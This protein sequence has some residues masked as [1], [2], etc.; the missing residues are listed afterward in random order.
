MD[1]ALIFNPLSR[2]VIQTINAYFRG[3][4]M[5]AGNVRYETME[6]LHRRNYLKTFNKFH[7]CCVKPFDKEYFI[8]ASCYVN[9]LFNANIPLMATLQ[10]SLIHE[11]GLEREHLLVLLE[12]LNHDPRE[13]FKLIYDLGKI[14][15]N[16]KEENKERIFILGFELNLKQEE[17]HKEMNIYKMLIKALDRVRKF[18]TSTKECQ[19]IDIL[20]FGHKSTLIKSCST[21]N[22]PYSLKVGAK[23]PQG[24]VF[25][26]F[27]GNWVYN[28]SRGAPSIMTERKSRRFINQL[29]TAYQIQK[30]FLL[31]QMHVLFFHEN[32]NIGNNTTDEIIRKLDRKYFRVLRNFQVQI[33]Y[34]RCRVDYTTRPWKQLAL[35]LRV[36]D[37]L[38][39]I[40]IED[41]KIQELS[42]ESRNLLNGYHVN[43]EKL[44]N[45]I[46][47]RSVSVE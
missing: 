5:G 7:D 36:C 1:E 6:Y 22:R 11:I 19:A 35:N 12:L 27:Q 26:R 13:K 38:K 42:S 10:I 9:E 45:P 8:N 14:A 41:I 44:V 32:L 37:L 20:R 33:V 30:V 31:L 3:F 25:I 40:A 17:I 24:E 34:D 28:D 15:I 47:H 23:T 16:K 18:S 4:V 46:S 2:S 39:G 29:P 21:R 43:L